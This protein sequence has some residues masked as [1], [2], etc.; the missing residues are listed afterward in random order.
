M[1]IK[2]RRLREV[3]KQIEAFKVLI[4]TSDSIG[5]SLIYQGQNRLDASQAKDTDC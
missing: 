1:T 4:E 2:N 5:E 3:N